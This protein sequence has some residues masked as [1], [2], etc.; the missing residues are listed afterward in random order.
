MHFLLL[1]NFYRSP[2]IFPLKPRHLFHYPTLPI[3]MKDRFL[4]SYTLKRTGKF[5]VQCILIITSLATN[6]FKRLFIS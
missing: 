5:T 1:C 6:G 2:V 4:H 3:H